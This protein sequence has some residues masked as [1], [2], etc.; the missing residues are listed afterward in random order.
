MEAITATDTA[1]GRVYR[2]AQEAGYI[3]MITADHGNAEQV[4]DV[5]KGTPFTAHTANVV[6][7]MMTGDGDVPKLREDGVEKED[8]EE[9][10][11]LCDVA[12]SI[13]DVML[14]GFVVHWRLS[15]YLGSS[16]ADGLYRHFS[17]SHCIH[18]YPAHLTSLSLTVNRACALA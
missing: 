12:P 10:G 16:I 3:L 4:K 15:D 17:P 5:E 2:A 7:F 18:C 6:P 14:R 8:F 13:L 1:V 11:A 9:A